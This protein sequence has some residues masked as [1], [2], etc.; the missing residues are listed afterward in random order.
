MKAKQV[1]LCKTAGKYDHPSKTPALG[2]INRIYTQVSNKNSKVGSSLRG[3]RRRSRSGER[4]AGRSTASNT[5]L[6]LSI[7]FGFFALA[8]IFA[9]IAFW[10]MKAESTPGLRS[11]N[12]FASKPTIQRVAS[13]SPEEAVQLV[14]T[15]LEAR[16]V[17]QL[18]EVFRLGDVKA[19][20][21]IRFLKQFEGLGKSEANARW[22]GMMDSDDLPLDIVV[23][24]SFQGS[25]IKE[26]L[27]FLTP[28][29]HG[30]WQIDFDS[31]ARHV[32]P[33]WSDLLNGNAKQGTVRVILSHDD[34]YN[35]SFTEAEWTCYRFS[36]PDLT[37]SLYGYCRRRSAQETALKIAMGEGK[38]SAISKERSIGH[39]GRATLNIQRG[40]NHMPDQF[41]ITEVLSGEW[42]IKNDAPG[43]RL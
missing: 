11:S 31:F 9:I 35:G 14:M 17:D 39:A 30:I 6:G 18:A 28:N 25:E 20:D 15:G 7:K 12:E 33:S 3:K 16:N 23:F 26:W 32:K 21:A 19:E 29:S 13:L 22:I 10:V 27:V 34:Y 24:Q 40:V 1:E 5:Q 41:E 4:F 38:A 37:K 2:H 43:K 8:F 42:V 36:S